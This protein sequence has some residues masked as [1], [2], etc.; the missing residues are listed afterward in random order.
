LE[1]D[2]DQPVELRLAGFADRAHIAVPGIVDEMV[3]GLAL[4]AVAQRCPQP[5]GKVGKGGDVAGV[6]LQRGRLSAERLDLAYN[7][8]GLVAPAA[9]GE[10]DVA[11]AAGDAEGGVAAEAAAAA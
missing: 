10:D 9:I 3:E 7:R 2:V 11:T 4:P 6:E 1:M 5:F 8:V